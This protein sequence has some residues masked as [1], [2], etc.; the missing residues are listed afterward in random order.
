MPRASSRAVRA[1]IVLV[2]ALVA[3][4]ALPGTAAGA[5]ACATRLL[6]DWSDN[7]RV[8]RLYE[9]HCYDEAIAAMPSDLRDYTDAVDVIER[10]LTS[11]V[12]EVRAS[13][14]SSA[15]FEPEPVAAL[16]A[17]S[18]SFPVVLV[19]FGVVFAT[20]LGAGTLAYAARRRSG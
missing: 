20:V 15:P 10:A 8:D 17:T 3:L 2:A 5:S 9:L 4:A 7:G 11:A 6:Q 19:V 1:C 12:R 16:E 13:G 18:S 14:R